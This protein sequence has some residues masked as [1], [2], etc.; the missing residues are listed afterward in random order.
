MIVV[1]G[2]ARPVPTQ[3]ATT[4]QFQQAQ[5][6]QS[7]PL[8]VSGVSPAIGIS[9]DAFLSQAEFKDEGENAIFWQRCHDI[10]VFLLTLRGPFSLLPEAAGV[11]KSI[12]AA[13]KH[14]LSAINPLGGASNCVNCAVALNATLQGARASAVLGKAVR[15]DQVPAVFGREAFD[16][17]FSNID[18]L[19]KAL[20][21]AG[22]GA[23][24]VV[25]GVGP[26][27]GHAFNAVNQGGVVQLLDGQSGRTAITEGFSKFY[28]LLNP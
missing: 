2:G 6:L 10:A 24:A 16:A 20:S 28:L 9:P 22:S 1:G 17:A 18:E 11:S 12:G 26:K 5:P 15:L 7:G 19:Q 25:V 8:Q 14:P 3:A 23:R 27:G 4:S 13:G 21:S